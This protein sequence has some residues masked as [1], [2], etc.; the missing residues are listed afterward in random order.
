MPPTAL[1]LSIDIMSSLLCSFIIYRVTK[2]FIG[3][4]SG[5]VLALI[6]FLVLT[7]LFVVGSLGI[8]SAVKSKETASPFERQKVAFLECID[9]NDV[10]FKYCQALFNQLKH[11]QK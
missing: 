4:R 2:S 6:I 5:E 9:K 7:P 1:I 8:D 3:A 11:L 10:D